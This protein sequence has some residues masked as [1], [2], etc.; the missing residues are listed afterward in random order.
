MAKIIRLCRR[1]GDSDDGDDAVRRQ[2]EATRRRGDETT[3][4]RN[5]DGGKND[6]QANDDQN[7]IEQATVCVRLGPQGIPRPNNAGRV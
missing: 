6:A 1:R 5:D 7:G 4:R 3:R 2:G